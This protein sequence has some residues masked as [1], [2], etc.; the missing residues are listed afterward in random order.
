[1]QRDN[2]G[3]LVKEFVSRSWRGRHV[4]SN[5]PKLSKLPTEPEALRLAIEG[6]PR[7]SSPSPA[8][9]RSGG[10][11][12]ERLIEI[13]TEPITSP[14][15][16][17][18]AF[19]A[20]AEILGI[21]LEHGVADV[22]GR[23]GDALTWVRDRGFGQ[24]LIFDPHTSKLLAQAEMIFGPPSTGEYDVPAGTVFRETAYLRSGIVGA[25]DRR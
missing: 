5:V 1:V 23:H 15:L 7:G 16:R 3:H 14:A 24:E 13:L 6:R 11:T 4:F 8:S 18:A 10:I 19:N 12:A 17:A 22:A 2:S 25:T 21:E 9:S 20:L